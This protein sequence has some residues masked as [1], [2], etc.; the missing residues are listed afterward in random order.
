MPLRS[1]GKSHDGFAMSAW[2]QEWGKRGCKPSICS[3]R[4]SHL[5]E[6]ALDR[7]KLKMH[8]VLWYYAPN[9]LQNSIQECISCWTFK[10]TPGIRDTSINQGFLHW[11]IW[12]N[13]IVWLNNSR[14]K[15]FTACLST[16]I[17]AWKWV[18]TFLFQW[19]PHL[20]ITHSLLKQHTKQQMD[21]C[22]AVGDYLTIN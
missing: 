13:C 3:P 8:G 4:F 12:S 17:V 20:I 7:L 21:I 16:H 9:I 15:M 11:S 5:K 1:V 22:L 2:A 14:L 6:M 10:S 19:D 18:I